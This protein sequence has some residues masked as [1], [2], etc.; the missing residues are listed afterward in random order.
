MGCGV[1]L[2][3]SGWSSRPASAQRRD[4]GAG[5]EQGLVVEQLHPDAEQPVGQDLVVVLAVGGH[6]VGQHERQ[7]RLAGL[8]GTD[9]RRVLVAPGRVDGGPVQEEVDLVAGDCR[10]GAPGQAGGSS[11][12]SPPG[13]RRWTP[14][15]TACSEASRSPPRWPG[16]C[17]TDP[18]SRP[19]PQV[20]LQP[21]GLG[22]GR[23]AAGGPCGRARGRRRRTD[24]D[25][26]ATD[27][28]RHLVG[29]GSCCRSPADVGA[30]WPGCHGRVIGRQLGQRDPLGAQREAA[31]RRAGRLSRSGP[32]AGAAVAAAWAIGRAVSCGSARPFGSGLTANRPAA[33]GRDRES[34]VR[35]V[36]R[37]RARRRWAG[38]CGRS[39]TSPAGLGRPVRR[40]GLRTWAAPAALGGAC[41]DRLGRRPSPG[42]RGAAPAG[43]RP[44]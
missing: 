41:R 28:D 44:A 43:R 5:G 37:R 3:R 10:L 8:T 38:A 26:D 7:G 13:R 33:C 1:I 2:T 18:P 36:V 16:R 42:G 15:G 20:V 35:P 17:S 39:G 40:A 12:L 14:P 29:P 31:A 23:T 32:A 25:L 6:Q 21:A 11:P 24:A 19:R 9:S 4:D 27:G 30:C 22:S 34:R